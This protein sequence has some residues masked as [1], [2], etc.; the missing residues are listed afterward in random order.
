MQGLIGASIES[1]AAGNEA[2]KQTLWQAVQQLACAPNNV[3]NF[4]A[5]Y[6]KATSIREQGKHANPQIVFSAFNARDHCCGPVNLLRVLQGA[7]F[8]RNIGLS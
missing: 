3:L 2:G 4:R 6:E 8:S 5:E 7:R 1:S